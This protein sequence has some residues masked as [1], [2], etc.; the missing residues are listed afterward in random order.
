VDVGVLRE[1][2]GSAGGAGVDRHCA[3][4]GLGETDGIRGFVRLGVCW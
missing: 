2:V 1:D 4:V 3:W